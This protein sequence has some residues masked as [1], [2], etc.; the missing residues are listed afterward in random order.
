M[1]GD[2]EGRVILTGQLKHN[3]TMLTYISIWPG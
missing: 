3:G 2:E 1:G